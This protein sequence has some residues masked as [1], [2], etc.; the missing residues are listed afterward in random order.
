MYNPKPLLPYING[1]VL[2]SLKK[3]KKKKMLSA[4]VVISILRVKKHVNI[5]FSN[6]INSCPAEPGYA[7]FLQTV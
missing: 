7:L 6:N 3:K 4:A 1:L 2:F 5:F